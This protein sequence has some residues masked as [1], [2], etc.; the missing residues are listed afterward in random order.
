MLVELSVMEQRYHAVMEALAGGVPIVEVAARYGSPARACTPGSAA[1]ATAG[2]PGWRVARTVRTPSPTNSPP[3]SRRGCASFDG[4]SPLGATSPGARTAPGRSAAAAL[5]IHR[6]P[7]PGAPPPGR[8]DLPETPPQRLRA[9]GTQRGD[10]VVAAEHHGLC[11][12][13]PTRPLPARSG[14][15]SWSPGSTIIPASASSPRSSP[16]RPPGRCAPR[17]RA[18]VDRQRGCSS[19]ASTRC[20]C[21]WTPPPCTCRSTEPT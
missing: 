21:G 10:A 1:T 7:G 20:T 2:C 11:H 6:L 19:P 16:A 13:R 3:R 9:V 4:P 8:R 14:R 12:D 18:G 5:A 17:A 15:S